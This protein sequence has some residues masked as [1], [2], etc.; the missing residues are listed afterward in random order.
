MAIAAAPVRGAARAPRLGH[1]AIVSPAPCDQAAS[2]IQF[3]KFSYDLINLGF[4]RRALQQLLCC[5]LD[6]QISF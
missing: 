5:A 1:Q 4:P 2:F 3:A 6:S